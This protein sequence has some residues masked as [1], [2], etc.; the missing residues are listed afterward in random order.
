MQ[1]KRQIRCCNRWGASAFHKR[2][3]QSNIVSK[4][5]NKITRFGK[6]RDVVT[7]HVGRR[8]GPGRAMIVKWRRVAT[9]AF[10]NG[11]ENLLPEARVFALGH[12]RVVRLKDNS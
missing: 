12:Y 5:A 1:I 2:H 11:Q 10:V 6:C 3:V 9:G 8:N 7:P 4:T